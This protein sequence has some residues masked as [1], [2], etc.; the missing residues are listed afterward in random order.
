MEEYYSIIQLRARALHKAAEQLKMQFEGDNIFNTT[1]QLEQMAKTCN[2]HQQ[3]S[4]KFIQ[5]VNDAKN[6]QAFFANQE[7]KDQL[8]KEEREKAKKLRL[9]LNKDVSSLEK[10]VQEKVILQE[11]K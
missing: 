4:E 3:R 1:K 9:Q 7:L 5:V 10:K 6:Q 2:D 8:I 11:Q